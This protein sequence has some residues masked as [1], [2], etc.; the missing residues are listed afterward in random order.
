[1]NAALEGLIDYWRTWRD[2]QL[3]VTYVLLGGWDQVPSQWGSKFE[4]E[5]NDLNV[6]WSLSFVRKE[7]GCWERKVENA[8]S[9]GINEVS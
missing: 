7:I 8:Y 1:M 2:T 5:L 9:S 6:A 4:L 3:E